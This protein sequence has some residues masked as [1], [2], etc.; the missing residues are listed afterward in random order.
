[1]DLQGPGVTTNDN[2]G[3]VVATSPANVEMVAR[4]GQPVPD[5]PGN[6]YRSMLFS[7]LNDAGLLTFGAVLGGSGTN[8]ANDSGVY[9][10]RPGG[11]QVEKLARESELTPDVPGQVFGQSTLVRTNNAGQLLLNTGLAG[12]GIVE[13]VNDHAVWFGTIDAP[14][15]RVMQIG[16]QAPGLAAGINY[17]TATDITLAQDGRIALGSTLGSAVPGLVTPS[18]D[19]AIF[20]GPPESLALVVRE[21][22]P[23]AVPESPNA[24]FA[25]NPTFHFGGGGNLVVASELTGATSGRDAALFAG[26]TSEDLKAVAVAGRRAPGTPAGTLFRNP[27][28]S[29]PGFERPAVN[30]HGQAAFIA[31]VGT[32][33]VSLTD[34]LYLYDPEQGLVLV[35]RQGGTIEIRPGEVRTISDLGIARPG[36]GQTLK[37]GPFNDDGTLVFQATFTDGNAGIF[38]ATVPLVGDADLDKVVSFADFQ[39]LERGFGSIDASRAM[40]DLNGDLAV[41]FADFM[42][43]KEHFGEQFGGPAIAPSPAE[44]A[45]LDAFAAAHVPEPGVTWVALTALGWVLGRRPKTCRRGR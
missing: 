24:R 7:S 43:L 18:N 27:S 2:I 22:N 31:R 28:G 34:A 10:R 44:R 21:G 6:V 8:S 15:T 33:T 32:N 45:A 36:N 42:L 17:T 29:N 9:F 3:L 26:T 39:A 41:T 11:T 30:A 20:T 38:T 12:A 37:G 35:A 25:G 1:M 40:G 16:N 13:D 19:S 23:A 4:K 5:A 14:L